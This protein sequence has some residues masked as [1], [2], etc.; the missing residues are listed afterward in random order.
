ME[1]MGI[2][3]IDL[4]DFVPHV[5]ISPVTGESVIA[6]TEEQHLALAAQGYTHTNE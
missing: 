6:E 3:D 5:M 2:E 4:D 1:W